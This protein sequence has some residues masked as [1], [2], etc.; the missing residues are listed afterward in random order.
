MATTTGKTVLF[1]VLVVILALM[2]YGPFLYLFS[3]PFRMMWTQGPFP[4]V[5]RFPGVF[6]AYGRILLL[7]FPILWLFVAVWAYSDAEKRGLNG[8]L[9][10][11][12]VF[13]GNIV[14]LIVY[15]LV[16]MGQPQP[17]AVRPRVSAACPTCGKP[18]EPDWKACPHC[19]TV[20]ASTCPSCGKAVQPDWKVCPYCQTTLE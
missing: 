2:F 13:V 18:I 6:F 4:G 16:R 1:V 19:Q 5:G 10:G 3:L 8:I 14:G 15:L 7:L 20:L 17:E 12:L 11:L 9:W